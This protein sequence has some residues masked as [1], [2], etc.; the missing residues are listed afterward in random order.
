MSRLAFYKRHYAA[1][2]QPMFALMQHG[3]AV[4]RPAAARKRKGLHAR[5]LAIQARLDTIAGAD[6]CT[7]GHHGTH[8]AREVNLYDGVLRKD[9]TPRK[10]KLAERWPCL[11]IPCPCKDFKPRA[12]SLCADKDLSSQRVI[13]FLY[14][15]LG[16]PKQRKR[17]EHTLTADEVALRKL[18][19][20]VSGHTAQPKA[21]TH[22]QREPSVAA[23]VLTL[24]LEHREKAKLI[25]YVNPDKFDPD[26][27]IRCMLKVT[28]EPGRL[29]SSRNPFGT[30]YNL[31]NIPRPSKDKPHTLIRGI[32]V[33]D[34]GHVF[35]EADYCLPGHTILDTPMGL[36]SMHKISV[37]DP[38]FAVRDERIV[39]NHVTAK[40]CLGQKTVWKLDL[41]NGKTIIATPEHRFP[42]VRRGQGIVAVQLRDLKSGDHLIPLRRRTYN[43]RVGLY[44]RS[45]HRYAMEHVLVAEAVYGP[46]PSAC[47]T[48]HIN[49]DK[50][51]N[52][53]GNLEY[54]PSK[55]HRSEHG[56]RALRN[57]D[58]RK[59]LRHLRR[60]K[61]LT[62][63]T[64]P[65]HLLLA[66]AQRIAGLQRSGLRRRRRQQ[67]TCPVCDA[68]FEAKI[69]ARRTFCSLICY[70]KR[71]AINHRVT[72]VAP[73]GHEIVYTITVDPDHNYALAAGVFTKNSQIEDRV[74]KVLSKD[75][76]AIRQARLRPAEFDAHTTSTRRI[77]ARIL[78]CPES[79]VE[80]TKDRRDIGKRTRHGVNYGEGAKT[81]WEI[82]LKDEQVLPLAQCKALIE[83]AQEPYVL[84]YQQETRKRIM[85]DR[86][87]VN[88]W[89]RRLDFDGERLNDETYRRG[90]AFRAASENAD[91]LNQLGLI[92]LHRYIC[93]HA[94]ASHIVAQVHDSLL[95]SCP[96]HEIYEVARF[97]VES[98][99]TERT[100]EG[101]ALAV[102]VEI[103]L[104]STWLCTREFK[105]LPTRKDLEAA[106]ATV[107][108]SRP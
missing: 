94:L 6:T 56:R 68:T 75:P 22:W 61:A 102:P 35:L 72:R 42:V 96:L 82:L 84:A 24:L 78:R 69:S 19:L 83:A 98:M 70:W 32:F 106:A 71:N 99:E 37:G 18:L 14:T 3:I 25:A 23:D 77:F 15:T 20:K 49:G 27:R 33:P 64:Y 51:D 107:L 10:P 76:E 1:L 73:H 46:R 31:Q 8:E 38:V 43:G 104:G 29:A 59:R 95:V 11:A 91:C 92:P 21:L 39:V 79:A 26:G 62:R 65:P 74:V 67:I 40:R 41:D 5:C 36:R 101:I 60:V 105:A 100:Y 16:L 48:H 30:G 52:R 81:L 2:M 7:C 12:P 93:D 9:G 85:R 55:Q 44:A 87:L 90:Y 13:A 54:V 86:V 47:D 97:L 28:T 108:A 4:D 58:N 103:K 89:G 66:A 63:G 57:V 80:I 17:V 50:R 45:L 88:S 53:P 34:A